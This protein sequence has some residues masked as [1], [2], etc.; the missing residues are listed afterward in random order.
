MRNDYGYDWKSWSKPHITNN[1]IL[2]TYVNMMFDYEPD[3]TWD[4]EQERIDR[5]IDTSVTTV[6]VESI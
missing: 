3:I 2:R 1:D 5:S 6:E 4:D